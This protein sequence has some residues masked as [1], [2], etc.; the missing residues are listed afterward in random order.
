MELKQQI[1]ELVPALRRYAY[2]LTGSMA[3]ADD[4]LQTT[5]ERLL[6]RPIPEDTALQAWAF[7]ICRNVW[8]DEHRKRQTREQAVNDP[9]LQESEH[10]G[11]EHMEKQLTLRKVH[12]AM[13]NLKDEQREIIG[14]IAIEGH[15]YKQVSE[16]MKIPVG[17]V[18]SRLARARAALSKQLA[19][20]Y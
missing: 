5:V 20:A 18:M 3:D 9:L 13:Q 2:S 11:D 4:L 15:S 10:K 14:L 6:T 8:I 12:D 7:R 16:A 1:T 17:T 19:G